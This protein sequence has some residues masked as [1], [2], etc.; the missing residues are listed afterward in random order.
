MTW[1]MRLGGMREA[2]YV[3]IA[4]ALH[5]TAETNTML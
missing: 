2:V 3:H 1:T 4:D 5:D